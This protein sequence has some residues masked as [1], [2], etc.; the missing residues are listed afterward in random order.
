METNIETI[1]SSISFIIQLCSASILLFGFVKIFIKFWLF[2][3][4]SF[5]L[6]NKEIPSNFKQ[7]KLEIGAYILLGLDFY[8]IADI[9]ESMVAQD[10]KSLIRLALVIVIRTV[11]GYFLGK[12]LEHDNHENKLNL[13][14][15]N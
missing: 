10:E 9:L 11:I 13:Q 1:I 14:K 4:K 2:E 15:Q 6:E 5:R 7:L 8:I 12:E 3:F